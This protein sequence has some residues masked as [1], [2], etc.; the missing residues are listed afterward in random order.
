MGMAE[1][2]N[3]NLPRLSIIPVSSN[4]ENENG[5][6]LELLGNKNGNDGISIIKIIIIVIKP[7]VII[8]RL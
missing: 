1:K 3:N 6:F 8:I 5:E 7:Y 4:D 2:L